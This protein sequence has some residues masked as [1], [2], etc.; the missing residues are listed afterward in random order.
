MADYMIVVSG[1]NPTHLGAL[2]NHVALYAKKAGLKSHGIEG[3]RESSWVVLDIGD[4]ILHIF[5]PESRDLYDIESMW[6]TPTPT[7]SKKNERTKA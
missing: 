1:N 6:L 3:S 4:I 2:A 7:E 5:M